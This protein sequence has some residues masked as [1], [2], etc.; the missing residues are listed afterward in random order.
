MSTQSITK[1]CDLA[2]IGAGPGGYTAAIRA[3]QLGA[4]VILIE[5]KKLG[6]ACT[7]V[8]CIPTKTLLNLVKLLS[9]IKKSKN[10]GLK[11]GEVSFDLRK[12]IHKKNEIVT[13]LMQGIKFLLQSNEIHTIIGQGKLTHNKKIEVTRNDGSKEVIN[14]TKIILAT[15]SKPMIPNIPGIDGKNIIFDEDACD[16]TEI[17]STLT[18]AGGGP[19]GVEFAYIYS[20]LGSEIT[21]IEML[22][23]I[24][25][26]EDPEIARYLQRKMVRNGINV[27]TN[28]RITSVED[29]STNKLIRVVHKGKEKT[30]KSEKL[31]VTL[32]RTPCISNL[33]L[34]EL[35]VKTSSGRIL[36]NKK[37][38]T[39]IKDVY[40]IGDVIGGAYAHEAMEE[41]T[42]AAENAFRNRKGELFMDCSI[43][44][45]CFFTIPQVA[46]V[47]LTEEEAKKQRIN[48]KV[49][50]FY[51]AS[52][53]GALTISDSEGFIKI[54][55]NAKS[56]RVIGVHIVGP[57]A[58]E[59]IAEAVLAMKL[60]ATY[61]DIIGTIHAHPTLSEALKEASMDVEGRSIHKSRHI[62]KT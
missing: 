12:I 21:V 31:V 37:M 7:N 52:N 3:A 62:T 54:L 17:P 59:L 5:E 58:S 1:S 53:A 56:K 30:V 42:I 13:E 49:G 35:G 57:N 41:G 6:G 23:H 47:G 45:R 61:E 20:Y 25:P 9:E 40:A 24:L 14:A 4:R 36:V 16:L 10:L 29:S 39:N 60:K 38:E 8:G 11:I 27:E 22:P 33:G 2:I 44:P 28:S 34:D 43:I 15:G 51:F 32:G 46:A 55:V 48:I 26:A 19:E 18:I 50:K